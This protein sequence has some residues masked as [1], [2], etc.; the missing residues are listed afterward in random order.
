MGGVS[1]G[2]VK[3]KIRSKKWNIT[4]GKAKEIY[5]ERRE[6]REIEKRWPARIRR[7]FGR[8]RSG[9]AKE[10]KDYRHRFLKTES[11]GVCIHCDL[12]ADETIAHIICE[13]PQLEGR[14][15]RI[16]GPDAKMSM[17]TT[18]P[19]LCRKFLSTRFDQ[20]DDRMNMEEDEGGGSQGCSG[21]Q[22]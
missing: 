19:E 1:Y 22:M 5:E 7:L 10:L 13:C 9:H 11:S 6:P 14:R 21:P 17:L 20:L 18:E 15:R 16:L 12:D 8:L 4:Y 3:A 2:I